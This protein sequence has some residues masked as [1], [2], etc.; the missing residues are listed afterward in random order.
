MR[1]CN[2]FD[3]AFNSSPVREKAAIHK[4]NL[5]IKHVFNVLGLVVKV[6]EQLNN[7]TVHFGVGFYDG[8]KAVFGM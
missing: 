4:L 2:T 7:F 6:A 5:R 1:S 8:S 3:K